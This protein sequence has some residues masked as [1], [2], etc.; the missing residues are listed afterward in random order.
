MIFQ[1]AH[2]L[3]FDLVQRIQ[4]DGVFVITGRL[5]DINSIIGGC[6]ID[7]ADTHNDIGAFTVNIQLNRQDIVIAVV[8]LSAPAIAVVVDNS[9]GISDGQD[10]AGNI[11]QLVE[12]LSIR[13]YG[14]IEGV[15]LGLILNNNRCIL[16]LAF[17]KRRKGEIQSD[18][19]Q[20]VA[21][22]HN[23]HSLTG[24]N[25]NGNRLGAVIPIAAIVQI[26]GVEVT[27]NT[28]QGQAAGFTVV[29]P[30]HEILGAVSS[31]QAI[32]GY[33]AADIGQ[34]S[35]I[36][37]RTHGGLGYGAAA[38]R[39]LITAEGS[40]ADQN[41]VRTFQSAGSFRESLACHHLITKIGMH[42]IDRGE[43]GHGTEGQNHA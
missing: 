16:R 27:G 15:S 30:G 23:I 29:C 4:L 2:D 20:I 25:A 19:L 39:D 37:F 14:S 12:H 1:T 21:V 7:V 41:T 38:A 11:A 36:A 5:T 22:D 31:F 10:R 42:G 6:T 3:S 33:S 28:I 18:G 35:R 13:L 32:N 9:A 43:A 24:R 8:N 40:Q 34:H 26:N 17:Y